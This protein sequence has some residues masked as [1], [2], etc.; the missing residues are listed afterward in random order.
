MK[1]LFH[2]QIRGNWAT[3]LLPLN[4][5]NSIDDNALADEIDRLIFFGVDG[6]YSN[7][8]AGEFYNQTE[9]EFDRINGILA[10]RCEK[11]GMPFQIGA[12]H[13][14]PV[15][16]VER[17]RRAAALKPS[18]IQVILPDWFVPTLAEDI[19][20]LLRLSEVCDPVGLVLYNPP[21]AKRVLTPLEIGK[22]KKNVTALTGVKVCDGDQEWY[23]QMRENC[24]GLSVFIPGHHLATGVASGAHGAYSNIACI[25]P[26]AA[27]RWYNQ[28][29]KD[30]PAARELETRIQCFMNDNIVPYLRGG[31][32]NMAVD[33]LMAAAGG[34][35][36]I[37]PRL[38]WPYRGAGESEIKVV[39]KAVQHLIPEFIVSE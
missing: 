39:H 21:H 4:R 6:I 2:D 35:C 14:S 23:R 13:M 19:D 32:S 38:R 12:S 8:S 30:M 37:H 29:K 17:A 16:A 34:W 20:F 15:L 24:T 5:D 28:M 7:G 36:A 27:Q 22:L 26:L 33:K 25:H 9:A 18:A 1:P 3:L 11:A 10:E 31:Y